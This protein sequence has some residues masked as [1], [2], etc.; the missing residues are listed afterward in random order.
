MVNPSIVLSPS[1]LLIDPT[2][3]T[4]M[5]T[6]SSSDG[7]IG[8]TAT[9]LIVMALIL[10]AL[11][12]LAV[13]ALLVGI[14]VWRRKKRSKP[15]NKQ[16]NKM[17]VTYRSKTSL[18]EVGQ[19]QSSTNGSGDAEIPLYEE[20]DDEEVKAIESTSRKG[21][22]DVTTE[23]QQMQPISNEGSGNPTSR[24]QPIIPDDIKKKRKQPA[25][26]HKRQLS[27]EDEEGYVVCNNNQNSLRG[28]LETPEEEQEEDDDKYVEVDRNFDAEQSSPETPRRTAPPVMTKK[29][30]HE[31][32][33]NIEEIGNQLRKKSKDSTNGDT[34][35]DDATESHNYVNSI[36]EIASALLEEQ[37]LEKQR[38]KASRTS[39]SPGREKELYVENMEDFSKEVKEKLARERGGEETSSPSPRTARKKIKPIPKPAVAQRRK[40]D[41]HNS[42]DTS[43]NNS[44]AETRPAE[45][46]DEGYI[47]FDPKEVPV[48]ATPNSQDASRQQQLPS[49]THYA[50]SPGK[51]GRHHYVNDVSK[52]V[53]QALEREGGTVAPS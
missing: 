42:K 31:Y 25:K 36:D 35:A 11:L 44:E 39:T 50:N 5:E 38:G 16:A 30:K 28:L 29:K 21:S 37:E 17:P 10:G 18:G 48:P 19:G 7:G 12:V 2:P 51:K 14:V 24:K 15:M 32:V 47:V 43:Y 1:P 13:V 33:N 27:D 34:A 40:K 41:S 6:D 45:E 26:V 23:V 20:V 9:G 49:D 4:T 53:Q 8:A 22:R 46:D 52:L 3:F